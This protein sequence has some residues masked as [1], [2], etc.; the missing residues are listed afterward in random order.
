MT[1]T[2][3]GVAKGTVM[4]GIGDS[5]GVESRKALSKTSGGGLERGEMM[6]PGASEGFEG[7]RDQMAQ[8]PNCC[9]AASAEKGGADTC[10]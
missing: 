10:T 3:G 6:M 1:G 2:V 4:A 8:P 9:F 7:R 5:G